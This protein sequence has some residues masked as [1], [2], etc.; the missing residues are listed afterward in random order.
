MLDAT[1][2]A[3]ITASSNSRFISE[4]ITLLIGIFFIVFAQKLGTLFKNILTR[5]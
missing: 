2:R 1:M 5:E 4:G 3:Q